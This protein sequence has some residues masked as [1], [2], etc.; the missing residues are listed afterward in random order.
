MHNNNKLNHS[1]LKKIII[2]IFVFCLQITLPAQYNIKVKINGYAES[3]LYLGYHYGIK[4]FITDTIKTDKK[5]N[6]VFAGNEKLHGGIYFIAFPSMDYFDILIDKNQNFSLSVDTS[7]FLKTLQFENSKENTLFIEYRKKSIET[8]NKIDRLY[9]I[10]DKYKNNRDSVKQ[11]KTRINNISNTFMKYKADLAIKNSSSFFAKILFSMSEPLTPKTDVSKLK[12]YHLN[13]D[14]VTNNFMYN[15]YKNH[16]FDNFDFTDERLLYSAIL[17]TKIHTFYTS[18]VSPHID[19]LKL[20]TAKLLAKAYS[21]DASYRFIIK[22]LLTIFESSGRLANDQ[23]FVFV[24]EN[25]LLNGDIDW[26][27][28]DF[29]KQLRLRVNSIKPNMAGKQAPNLILSDTAGNQINIHS[30]NSNYLVLYFW[31]TK[32]D[33]C[34]NMTPIVHNIVKKYEGTVKFVAICTDTDKK[35]WMNYINKE[36]LYDWVNAYDPENKNNIISLYD[37]Y[38]T[39][40]I[41]LLDHKKTII[42]KD[43]EASE[44]EKYL[45]DMLE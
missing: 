4:T 15:Y 3:E 20:E 11:I 24:A 41:Y 40:R 1:V 12:D 30:I 37:I 33:H 19:S 26:M 34:R 6:G 38:K 2:I 35:M 43:I 28:K 7:D 13:P 10:M 29:L 45:D 32:C 17:P 31:D 42:A 25:Y 36:K 14:S 5:G 27:S 44:L 16:Y 23:L 18:V 22:Y 8:R 39:P 9:A 21:N